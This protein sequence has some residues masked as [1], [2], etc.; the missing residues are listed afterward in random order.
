MRPSLPPAV[1]LGPGLTWLAVLLVVPCALVLAYSFFER[2]VYGGIDYVFT[3][4]NYERAAD[5]LYLKI[6]WQSF[7]IA[8]ITTVLALL[9]GYPAAYYI[10][11]CSPR[12]Q[13]VLLVLAILPFWSNYLIR[14]YAWIVLLNRE[15][16]INRALGALGIADEPLPLLYNQFSIVVGLLYAYLPLHDPRA[17]LIDRAAGAGVARGIGRPRRRLPGDTRERDPAAHRAGYRSR[18]RIRV[19]AEHPATSS[20]PI[21]SAVGAASW[22]A[23]SSTTSSSPR[24]TGRSAP[25]SPSG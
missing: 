16:L 15:G 3:L 20:L 24:A 2:G 9:I 10:S 6:F 1:L 22:S 12:R 8:I 13:K 23:T 25:R 21:C 4:E 19:R 14:T 18:L 17:L 5:P 11:L 7:R